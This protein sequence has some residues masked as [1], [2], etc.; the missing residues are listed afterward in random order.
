[1]MAKNNKEDRALKLRQV[2]KLLS[3]SCESLIGE[4]GK[5]SKNGTDH[6]KNHDQELPSREAFEAERTIKA[7]LGSIE[8]LACTPSMRLMEFSTMF[9]NSRALHIAAENNIPDLLAEKDSDGV[10]VE[11]ISE[12][13]GIEKNKLARILRSLTSEHIFREVTPGRFANNTM[14]QALVNNEPLR[15]YIVWG[16][17]FNYTA[18]D[19]LP[20]TLKDS[21]AGPSYGLN[22]TALMRA[23]SFDGPFYEWL[24]QKVPATEASKHYVPPRRSEGSSASAQVDGDGEAGVALVERP[25]LSIFNT[26]MIGGGKVNGDA[27]VYDYPWDQ[28]GEATVVDVG[29]GVGGFPLQ[30]YS[31]YPK[32]KFVVQDLQGM[33]QEAAGVWEKQQP[34]ALSSGR[35]RLMVHNFFDENPIKGAEVYWMRAVT[36]NWPDEQVVKILE[37][38][39]K[40]MGHESRVLIADQVMNTTLGDDLLLSAPPPLLANYGHALP[41]SHTRDMVMMG[42]LNGI[43]RTPL[44]FRTVIEKAGLK[45]SRIWQCRSQVSIVECRLP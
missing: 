13:V 18:S 37:S 28:L 34:T 7:A 43:E 1:M 27:H 39:R 23:E 45:V 3:S 10:D 32:L 29:G 12:A 21:V 17:L 20:S 4:W 2:V 36:H 15:A 11:T 40:A 44:Q 25:Q 22:T 35:A 16:G 33:I 26:A 9:W 30:L 5:R 19:H 31:V 24:K 42:L 6:E 8:E 14:S 41:Y 38:I